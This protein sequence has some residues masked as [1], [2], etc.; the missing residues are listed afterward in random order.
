MGLSSTIKTDLLP[1]YLQASDEFSEHFKFCFEMESLK[2]FISN[3]GLL[4]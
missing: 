1:M 2:E 4:R 3:G